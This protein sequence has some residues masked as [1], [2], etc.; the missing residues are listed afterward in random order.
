MTFRMSIAMNQHDKFEKFVGMVE[1]DESYFGARR[2][3]GFHGKLKR[4]RG[5]MR[6]PVFRIFER[7]W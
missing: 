2:K 4:G 1:L 5:T 6:Q 7:K 3:R